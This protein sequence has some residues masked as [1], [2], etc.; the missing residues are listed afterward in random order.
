MSARESGPVGKRKAAKDHATTDVFARHATPK[1]RDVP[2]VGASDTAPLSLRK[3]SIP[4]SGGT[5]RTSD[6]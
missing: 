4:E 1:K 2:D 3:A 6:Q 5:R